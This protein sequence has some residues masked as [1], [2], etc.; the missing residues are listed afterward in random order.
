MASSR[1]VSFSVFFTDLD[2]CSNS[3]ASV[4]SG[5]IEDEDIESDS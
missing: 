2:V 1:Y 5:R 4:F 3:V